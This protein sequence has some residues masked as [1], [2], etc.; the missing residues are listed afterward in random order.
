MRAQEELETQNVKLKDGVDQAV[1]RV[2]ARVVRAR[3]WLRVCALC[4]VSRRV[5]AHALGGR[6]AD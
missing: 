6:G 1:S 2:R 3:V 4:A 5:H